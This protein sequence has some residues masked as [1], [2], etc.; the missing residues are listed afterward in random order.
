MT[1]E[2]IRALLRASADGMTANELYKK[3]NHPSFACK[4][5]C[6]T[7]PDVYIDRWEMS[8][9]KGVGYAPVYVAVAVPENTPKPVV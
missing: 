4:C 9:R 2:A 3:L 8:T 6:D 5:I 7:M 1:Q